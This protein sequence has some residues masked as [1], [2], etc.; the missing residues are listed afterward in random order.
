MELQIVH[1]I[2]VKYFEC[3]D[4]IKVLF[5]FLFHSR[6]SFF[7]INNRVMDKSSWVYAWARYTEAEPGFEIIGF[8]ILFFLSY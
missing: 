3:L 4:V 5:F 7:H 1:D 6:F 8:G 2:L